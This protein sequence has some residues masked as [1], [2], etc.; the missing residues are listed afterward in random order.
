[1]TIG[2]CGNIDLSSLAAALDGHFPAADILVGKPDA[3]ALEL[4]KTFTEV[5]SLET[6][7]IALDWR[8]FSPEVYRFGFGDSTEKLLQYFANQCTELS[9]LISQFRS[10][11]SARILLFAPLT[12]AFDPT[13]FLSRLLSPSPVE[14]FYTV[15]QQFNA[16]CRSHTDC[17]PIDIDHIVNAIGWE[18]AIN[19]TSV[20]EQPQPFTPLMTNAIAAHIAA[21]LTQLN[22]YPLKCIVLDMDNT[23]WGGVVSDIGMEQL[24]IGNTGVGRAFKEFQSSLVRLHKQGILLAICSKNNTCDVLTVLERHSEMLIR[25]WMIACYR[26][27]WDDKPKNMVEIARE[28]NIGLDAI[29]FIDDSPFERHCM[30]AAL[31]AVTTLTLPENPAG[32][33]NALAQCT[34]LWPV[35]LTPDDLHKGNVFQQSTKQNKLEKQALNREAYLASLAINVTITQASTVSFPRIA[36][37]LNKTNQFNLTTKRYTQLELE[38]FAQADQHN[39]VWCLSM[40][41]TL[42][43]YG[44]IAAGVVCGDTLDAFVLSC[45]AFGRQA[46]RALLH[47]VLRRCKDEGFSA[48][49]GTFLATDRNGMAQHFFKDSGFT[50]VQKEG[51]MSRWRFDLLGELPQIPH[52]MTVTDTTPFGEGG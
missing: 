39:H 46:E 35:Q 26:I 27:N 40:K 7:V 5:S 49:F 25:P 18:R 42:G 16:L 13:G 38:T 2:L 1:M 24:L 43:T 29:L 30:T 32:F 17:Y 51:A 28:L 50:L 3:F 37:L 44:I 36:Q 11:S 33:T 14:F 41:D 47:I 12:N 20:A 4:Q 34:R 48:M 15:Q 52:W 8:D 31:P 22:R 10:V 45:R 9:G 19:H 6:C 23:I 21:I